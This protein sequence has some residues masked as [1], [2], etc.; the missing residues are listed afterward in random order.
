MNYTT[1]KFMQ[2]VY[3]FVLFYR[4]FILALFLFCTVFLLLNNLFIVTWCCW[5]LYCAMCF[6]H[7]PHEGCVWSSVLRHAPDVWNTQYLPLTICFWE[8]ERG[9]SASGIHWPCIPSVQDWLDSSDPFYITFT[10]IKKNLYWQFSLS[11]DHSWQL[12]HLFQ[13]ILCFM[14]VFLCYSIII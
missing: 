9:L 12:Q 5:S 8:R 1:Y 13:D 4:L 6:H 11:V 10:S 14:R 3:K 7:D 2:T